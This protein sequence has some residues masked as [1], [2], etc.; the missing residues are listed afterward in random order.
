M[1]ETQLLVAL[2]KS[3]PQLS[4]SQCNTIIFHQL[5]VPKTFK[6]F[7]TPLFSH[8]PPW[9]KPQSYASGLLSPSFQTC[10]FTVC[11]PYNTEYNT[12]NRQNNLL[13][14]QVRLF[15]ISAEHFSCFQLTLVQSKVLITVF[16]SLYNLT[17]HYLFNRIFYLTFLLGTSPHAGH[18]RNFSNNP[19]PFMLQ[20]LYM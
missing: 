12:Y 11:A 16:K 20:D 1:Y 3:V 9:C 17:N 19:S 15:H 5:L 8:S 2:S 4:P 6:S 14:S 7:L 13:K 10:P 18:V